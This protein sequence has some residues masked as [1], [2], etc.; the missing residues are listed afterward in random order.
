MLSV[1]GMDG[2][3]ATSGM[4]HDVLRIRAAAGVA[5]VHLLLGYLLITGLAASAQRRASEGIKL[6]DVERPTLPPPEEEPPPSPVAN[7]EPEGAAAAPDRH[8]TASPI[9]A[10]RPK[11]RIAVP[12]PLVAATRPGE[13]TDRS[14]GA[15]AL[16]GPGIGVGGIG[17]GR[18]SGRS[19]EGTGGGV[20]IGA[21]LVSGRIRNR[22]YPRSA[23]RVGEEG[24]V[25][26]QFTVGTDGRAHGCAI[27]Q[28]SGNAELDAT[29]CRLIEKRFRYRPARNPAGLAV[30]E[31]KGW[32]QVWWLEPR[33][34]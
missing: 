29:T 10:P 14:S 13:G 5:A 32:K 2:S 12:P 9:P 22:D 15:A 27:R 19:G 7:R 8:A 16:P 23:A 20:A 25:I 30:P 21:E 33:G 3:M 11:I 17:D 28:T 6:F 26:A 24:T 31:V 34:A 4:R 1:P 18:G